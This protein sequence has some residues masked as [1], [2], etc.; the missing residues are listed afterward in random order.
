M[1]FIQIHETVNHPHSSVKAMIGTSMF[2]AWLF[3]RIRLRIERKA[4]AAKRTMQ[5]TRSQPLHRDFQSNP[6]VQTRIV[7][8]A[9][10]LTGQLGLANQKQPITVVA[11]RL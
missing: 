7:S 11:I 10:A 2:R 5:N 6:E 9:V 3:I 1:A 4:K 8:P